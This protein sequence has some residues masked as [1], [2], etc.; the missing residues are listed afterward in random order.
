MFKNVIIGV[1]GGEGG[2]DAIA[3][4]QRLVEPDGLITL[5]H[6]Y[7]DDPGRSRD[8]DTAA[9]ETAAREL[10]A[11][12]A[13]V[14][15]LDRAREQRG[16][17]AELR[18]VPGP[19][20]GQGL[21]ASAQ[22]TGADLLVV[23][24][25]RRG[26]LDRVLLRDDTH[27]AL[28]GA[29]CPVAIA[30]AGYADGERVIRKIG[31][32]YNESV[33]SENAVRCARQ[34]AHQYGATVSAFEAVALPSYTFVGGPAPI[35][36]GVIDDLVETAR[37]RIEALGEIEPHAA[38][39]LTCEELSRYSAS[40]DL[41]VIGSRDYGPVGR[42]AHGGTALELA[43]SAQ[44]PLLVLTRGSRAAE[45]RGAWTAGDPGHDQA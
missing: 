2:R 29:A 24:S 17:N 7:A 35:D 44:C 22:D 8:S 38:Y 28:N 9:D 33:E 14:G 15:L 39:G 6:V 32:G 45:Q 31:V 4:A 21:R 23:G 16:I 30:P 43:Q 19:S 26:P 10:A 41:L 12:A 25:S 36:P 40:V 3:L 1:D 37:A 11:R 27:A 18:A 42:I 20:P 34:L 13:A 5:V